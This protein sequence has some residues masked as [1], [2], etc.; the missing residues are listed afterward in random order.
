MNLKQMHAKQSQQKL[1][2]SHNIPT[3]SPG[4]FSDIVHGSNGQVLSKLASGDTPVNRVSQLSVDHAGGPAMKTK[5]RLVNQDL[6]SN[7]IHAQQH[8]SSQ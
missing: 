4:A 7:G 3:K 2:S 8:H 1:L 6:H 5:A